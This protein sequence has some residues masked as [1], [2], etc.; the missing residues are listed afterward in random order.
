VVFLRLVRSSPTPSQ[1]QQK[2][3]RLVQVP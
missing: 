2:P 1:T 3:V